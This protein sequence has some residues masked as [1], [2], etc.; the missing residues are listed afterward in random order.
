MLQNNKLAMYVYSYATA[1]FEIWPIFKLAACFKMAQA[2][3]KLVSL[4]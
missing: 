3:L 2:L 1:W 4:I